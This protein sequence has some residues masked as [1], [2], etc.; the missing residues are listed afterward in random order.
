MR[1]LVNLHE[2]RILFNWSIIVTA[3]FLAVVCSL[4]MKISPFLLVG[5]ACGVIYILAVSFRPLLGTY[6]YVSSI[7]FASFLN[8]PITQDGLSLPT[9]LSL[10]ALMVYLVRAVLTD[11][12]D[13]IVKPTSSILHLSIPLMLAVMIISLVNSRN[14]GSS[15][16]EI[17]QFIYCLTAYFL[18]LFTVRSMDQL[19][20]IIILIVCTGFL[21]SF[22]GIM[23]AIDRNIYAYL[24]NKSI[25]GASLARS[26]LW[27]GSNRINGLIGDA[28][29]H[30]M[31][32]G[33]LFLLALYLFLTTRRKIAKILFTII[34]LTSL[35][36]IIGAASRGAALGF[37]ISILTFWIFIDLRGK[38][39]IL[40][41][42]FLSL[43]LITF[44]MITLIPELDI[45]RFYDPQ[46]R[47][48][49]Y[50]RSNNILIG[51]HMAKDH[52][53]IGSGPD[54]FMLNYLNY[55]RKVT[56]AARRIPTKPLNAFVQALVEYGL[57]GLSLFLLI[58]VYVVKSLFSLF[59]RVTKEEKTFVLTIFAVFSGYTFFMNT[60][61]FFV[62]KIYWLLVT[63]AGTLITVYDHEE[64]KRGAHEEV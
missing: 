45:D 19:R 26:V 39:I 54:G 46:A 10:L 5:F 47:K 17:K 9:T 50:L 28:D 51:L 59:K 20:N 43:V 58:N 48:T 27:T 7:G 13:L 29:M 35:F 22:F 37:L 12:R 40:S 1:F 25:F 32:M 31:Y 62:N 41:S 61:G 24:H 42:I 56:P 55:A 15:V 63:L 16:G 2:P 60:T 3:L 44:S 6:G 38:W 53:V 18:V 52:P 33:V 11:D 34:M 8:V 14:I 49:I 36:N 23:E 57:L 4:F 64:S 21:V 30:G